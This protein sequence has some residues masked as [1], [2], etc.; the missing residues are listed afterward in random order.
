MSN[1]NEPA[2]PK[3]TTSYGTGTAF[4]EKVGLNKR[5]HAAIMLR[6]PQS[7]DDEIDAMIRTANRKDF[8]ALALQGLCADTTSVAIPQK[9]IAR[10]A[11]DLADALI[12][13][14][15]KQP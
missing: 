11:V 12:A 14:L 6:I 7:G 2:F 5:E 4:T 3:I 15:E 8:A 13:E 10:S 9:L 1:A